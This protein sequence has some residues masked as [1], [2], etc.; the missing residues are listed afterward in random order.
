MELLKAKLEEKKQKNLLVSSYRR[1]YICVAFS[2]NKKNARTM[3]HVEEYM[4]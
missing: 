1:T 2:H 3:F 4:K